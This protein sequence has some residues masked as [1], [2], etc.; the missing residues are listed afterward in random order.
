MS[1]IKRSGVPATF[2]IA[3]YAIL[4]QHC[5]DSF[6][7]VIADSVGAAKKDKVHPTII[8]EK[9]AGHIPTF[10]TR[11]SIAFRNVGRKVRMWS[12]GSAVG[13]RGKPSGNWMVGTEHLNGRQHDEEK[14]KRLEV[15]VHGCQIAFLPLE[16]V[17]NK[18]L[19]K[20]KRKKFGRKRK[21]KGWKREGIYVTG[22]S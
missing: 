17:L 11:F 19:K 16:I 22:I 1:L 15:S 21:K 5:I 20:K 8:S 13:L 12:A 6:R 10:I 18:K 4:A 2:T 3:V 9:I 7:E 14:R